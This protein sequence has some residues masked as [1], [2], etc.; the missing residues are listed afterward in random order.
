VVPWSC[1]RSGC[2]VDGGAERELGFI[3]APFGRAVTGLSTRIVESQGCFVG[4]RCLAFDAVLDDKCS[5]SS[6]SVIEI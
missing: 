1:F 5:D 4:V 6:W 2:R 3:R